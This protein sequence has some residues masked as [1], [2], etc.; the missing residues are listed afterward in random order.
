VF[1]CLAFYKSLGQ[2]EDV[3]FHQEE[4]GYAPALPLISAFLI[5]QRK[6]TFSAAAFQGSWVGTV[7]AALFAIATA[8]GHLAAVPTL[9]QYGIVF[10]LGSLALALTGASS[11]RA[12][13]APLVVL[14]LSIPL[15]GF[16]IND[17]S[18][19]LQLV[20]SK[21]GVAFIRLFGISVYLE[22]NVIDLGEYKLQVAEACSGLRY[23][24]PLMT[25][26]FLVAY[27][28][29]VAFWKRLLV[30]LSSIPITILMN[31]FRIGVIGVTVE[32]WGIAMAEGFLHEFQGWV[33]FMVS[34]GLLL[35][36][37]IVLA[38][39]GRE[40]RPWREV[41]GVE[42]PERLS[43]DRPRLTQKVPQTF[44]I[45]VTVVCLLAGTV[46]LLP[47]RSE[48]IQ[49]RDSFSTYPMLVR[50]WTGRR[51]PLEE[52]YLQALQLDDYI[53]ADY[54]TRGA[55][56]INLYAAWYGSQRSGRA[57][58]SPRT[59]LPGGGWKML[60]LAEV[61]V[62]NAAINSTPLRVNR[63]EIA[64]GDQRQLV[65]YWFQQR[66]R[67]VTSEYAVKWYLFWDSLVR[68]R[69][70]G[71]LIRLITPISKGEPIEQGDRRLEEFVG[72]IAPTIDNYIP[73]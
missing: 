30:F 73:K 11:F 20:S 34:I 43:L 66:G 18:T 64:F 58:H 32:H 61:A 65:Y 5:W 2:I 24:L 1:L 31:S 27:F 19:Q 15:P 3:W 26:G 49:A 46:L 63:A 56:R 6:N 21:L 48:A 22:G 12:L 4:F 69:T 28:F 16:L 14:G 60:S 25:I 44:T 55:R 50:Q 7:L 33:L 41:F 17:I 51:V 62:P 59:C 70:D 45:G 54:V 8:V 9:V 10:T 47:E 39:I 52:V 35:T 37:V 57:T 29:K 40:S 42:L 23:L 53:F 67:I 13:I 36:E 68:N 72:A 71:A 38:R